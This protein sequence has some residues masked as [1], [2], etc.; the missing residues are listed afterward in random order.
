MARVEHIGDATLHL[1]DCRELLSGFAVSAAAVVS[2]PP[3]G[4]AYRRGAGGGTRDYRGHKIE[5]RNLR[6][7]VGDAE[8]FDPTPF[9]GFSAVLLWGANHF[10]RRL[11]EG[12]RWLAW[13]KLG[14][15]EPW[16]TFSDV[17]F[18]WCSQTGNDR[19]FSHLWK[20]LCQKGS[21]ERRDHPTQKP[22][23]LME[24]CL[25]FVPPAPVVDPFMGVGTTGV[26][27]IRL[28]RP[29][30][31]VEIERHYFDIACRRIEEAQRQ[32]DM[33]RDAPSP[34][35]VQEAML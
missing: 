29:F 6:A 19:I 24:W 15:M 23:A 31:G 4:I 21:G 22:V 7:I 28:G 11:P 17:E 8:P 34:K 10:A 18:A 26:A 32:G 5:T 20:G 3:Y 35:P 9:L 12:G 1:G 27:C 13:N 16:D 30:V 14:G 33:F 2:D 25:G